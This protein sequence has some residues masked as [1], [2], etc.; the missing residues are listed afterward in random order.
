MLV[1]VNSS[2][3][4]IKSVSLSRGLTSRSKA[5]PL[6]LVTILMLPRLVL[7]AFTVTS[8]ARASDSFQ[9][10]ARRQHGS[11]APAIVGAC[12]QVRRRV[13]FFSCCSCRPVYGC[14]VGR[15][16]DERA[17]DSGEPPWRGRDARHRHP[18]APDGSIV[19]LDHGGRGN[20][21]VGEV[22][23]VEIQ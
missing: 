7:F 17:L 5:A 18:R 12:V 23:A 19:S 4:R 8:P 1:P 16:I 15:T 22:A 6:T 14:F 9:H 2:S 20:E 21:R 10:G 13:R 3:C 11:H